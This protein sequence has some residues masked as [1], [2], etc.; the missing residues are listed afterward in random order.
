MNQISKLFQNFLGWAFSMLHFTG[1]INL[2]NHVISLIWRK[3]SATEFF[4]LI[5][6]NPNAARNPGTFASK[7]KKNKCALNNIPRVRTTNKFL[8]MG[9]NHRS[10]GRWFRRSYG[11]EFRSGPVS[12]TGRRESRC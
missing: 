6:N 1:F 8:S 11:K 2:R 3:I 7:I 4:L 12:E 10:W 5:I 9:T